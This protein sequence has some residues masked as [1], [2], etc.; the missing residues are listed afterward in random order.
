MHPLNSPTFKLPGNLNLHKLGQNLHKP[1]P[2][3]QPLPVRPQPQR[4]SL[5]LSQLARE[6][7]LQF[8]ILGSVFP[9]V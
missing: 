4:P 7:W 3:V 5:P 6:L 9:R 2:S 1:V 8:P